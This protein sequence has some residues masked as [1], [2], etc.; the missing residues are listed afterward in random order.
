M[1]NK[2]IKSPAREKGKK[3]NSPQEVIEKPPEQQNPIF[4]LHYLDGD[5][6]L[7]KCETNDQAAFARKIHKL[8][9]LT[10]A[11]I[12]SEDRHSLGYERIPRHCLK[13]NIPKFLKED[14]NLI[15]FRFHGK[16]AMVGY[17]DRAVFYVIWLDRDFTLY[18]HS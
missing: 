15:A 13:V 16:K 11:K 5:Y 14:A 8:S 10:W 18:D 9:K 1:S 4:S 12:Q 17:R 7:T 2:K 6:C 3:I